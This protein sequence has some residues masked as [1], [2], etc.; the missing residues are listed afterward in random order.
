MALLEENKHINKCNLD[1]HINTQCV[2]FYNNL[3][4]QRAY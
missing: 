3:L 4:L 2:V 1:M